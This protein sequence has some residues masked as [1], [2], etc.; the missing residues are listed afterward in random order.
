MRRHLTTAAAKTAIIATIVDKTAVIE[1]AVPHL[2]ML[3]LP[4]QRG[5]RGWL[6]ARRSLSTRETLSFYLTKHVQGEFTVVTKRR[7]RGRAVCVDDAVAH[8]AES[9][10]S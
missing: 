3:L 5:G 10:R 6:I 4:S 1:S 9:K 2:P 7:A 8:G